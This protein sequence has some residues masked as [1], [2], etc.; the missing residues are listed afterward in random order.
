MPLATDSAQL[1]SGTGDLYLAY[2]SAWSHVGGFRDGLTVRFT[3]EWNH[4]RGFD[5]SLGTVRS[6]LT[7][8][9]VEVETTFSEATINALR[10]SLNMQTALTG[11]NSIAYLGFSFVQSTLSLKFIGE[12]DAGDLKT[13]IFSHVMPSGDVEATYTRN[14]QLMLPFRGTVIS[15]TVVGTPTANDRATIFGITYSTSL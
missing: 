1:I 13:W 5:Q 6:V 3:R 10:H 4:M 8:V 14:E 15:T 7:G 12:D 2:T 9:E 11:G